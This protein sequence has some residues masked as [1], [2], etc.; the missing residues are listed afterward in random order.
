MKTSGNVNYK[1]AIEFQGPEYIPCILR[2]DLNWLQE[3][4][5]S[6]ARIISELQSQI[7][8]DIVC[9]FDVAKN[10]EEPRLVDGMTRWIDEWG[11][12]W[13]D[14]GFGAKTLSP[15]LFLKNIS[16]GVPANT[17]GKSNC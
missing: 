9:D 14:D 7:R 4:D 12:G 10:I 13:A 2:V 16:T 15:G 8:Q 3:K 1:K 5:D 11:T 6:K 17:L